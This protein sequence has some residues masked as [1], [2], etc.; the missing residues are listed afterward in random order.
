MLE[1]IASINEYT[2]KPIA[3][4]TYNEIQAKW[5]VENLQFFHRQS[6]IFSKKDIV[7]YDYVAES[8]DLAIFKNR[9]T[10]QNKQQKKLYI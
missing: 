5:I 2:K 8:K 1:T 4:I 7:T 9:S 10:K 6:N 3:I